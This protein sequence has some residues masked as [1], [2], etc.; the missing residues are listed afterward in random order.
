MYRIIIATV[1]TIIV[2]MKTNEYN[3]N[4]STNK[5]MD[6][7]KKKTEISNRTNKH[8]TSRLE[9]LRSV[10]ASV[11]TKKDSGMQTKQA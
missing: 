8:C 1:A 3:D 9:R 4:D 7:K 6:I 5:A 2:I 10:T 11:F